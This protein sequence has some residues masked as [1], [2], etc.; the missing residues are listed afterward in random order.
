MGALIGN[1]YFAHRCLLLNVYM[2]LTLKSMEEQK[3]MPGFGSDRFKGLFVA[4]YA[5]YGADGQVSASAVR[6]LVNEYKGCR[7][8][9]LYVGGSTGEGLLQTVDERKRVLEAVME[10]AGEELTII[11]HVGA[12]ATRD[13][14][15]LARH[16]RQAGA[17]A[18]SAVPSIY[19]PLSQQ[20]VKRHWSAIVEASSLP[21]IMYHIPQTTGFHLSKS[22]FAEMAEIGQ[23]VGLKIS[24][25]SVQEL[26]AFKEIAGP[27]FLVYNGP[28]EQ[29]LA[30]R[31]M[32]A[33]GGIGG[34]YGVMPELFVKLETCFAQGRMEE[35]RQWQTRINEIIARLYQFP[36]MLA[37][38][39]GMLKLRGLDCGEPRPPL[40]PLTG[41][42]VAGVKQLNDHILDLVRL[43]EIER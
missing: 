36:S 16:A 4:M 22:L 31:C 43:A 10:E 37:A 27:D 1:M 41:Q 3:R 13:S 24:S 29:Y 35:A 5:C 30:G 17:H 34:T 6:R 26:H 7:M 25:E 32:G 18:V 8:R 42:D 12:P 38:C 14:V 9:G 28:D 11:V 23:V 39:K 2:T 40:L 19:Y 21:F 33:D 20:A 15:A